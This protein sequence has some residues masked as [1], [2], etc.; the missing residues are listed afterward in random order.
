[1]ILISAADFRADQ[2]PGDRAAL[3]LVHEALM[4]DRLAL[5]AQPIVD[6]AT[7][8]VA[9]EELLLR[10]VADDGELIAATEFVPSAERHGL[11]PTLDRVVIERAARL[12]SWGRSVHANLSATTIADGGL[13]ED[14][15]GAV[16]RHGADPARMT[17]EITE[18][19]A[20]PDMAQARRLAKGLN[21]RGFRIALD[22]FGTGWGAFRYLNALPVDMIKID[23]EFIGDLRTSATA[24]HLVRSMVGLAR[25]L[26]QST[27][28]EGV[29]DAETLAM[30][31]RLGVGYAQGFHLGRPTLILP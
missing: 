10:I 2:T 20:T 4:C 31:Q 7:G 17:F 26:G 5:H 30:L 13:L 16:R 8:L 19:A 22:D 28:G 18:T 24:R 14:I 29:E 15:V 11:M 3:D 12:A 9:C 21:A 25:R 23:R 6:L 27:V 1:M